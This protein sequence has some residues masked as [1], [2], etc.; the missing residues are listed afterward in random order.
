MANI[1]S[2]AYD[3][4][5]AS[6]DSR[7]ESL[8]K[9]DPGDLLKAE[10]A[11]GMI[12][13]KGLLF[14]PYVEQSSNA[15]L[16]KPKVSYL[17][18]GLL[19]QI[20]RRNTV[21]AL[22]IDLR[23]SQIA[24][25]C[26]KQ[27]SRFDLGFKIL[28]KDKS[29]KVDDEEVRR[30]EEFLLNCGYTGEERASEDKMTLDQWGY[31]VTRDL[32]VYGHCAIEKVRRRDGDLYSFLPLPAETIY[33]ANRKIDPKT[34]EGMKNIWKRILDENKVTIDD[35]TSDDVE[36]IQVI[37]GKC[38]EAFDRNELI[39]SRI[40][41][42]SDI[43]LNGYAVGP[44][45]RAIS[46][47]TSHLQIENHQR[48][49]FTHGFASKGLLVIQGD[50]TTTTLKALQQMWN[51]QITGPVNSWRTPI[52]AGIQG[53]QWTPLSPNSRDMEYAA[54][55]DYVLRLIFSAFAIDPEEVGF[56]Y[57]SRGT[58]Q[59]SLSE[60]SNEWKLT[61]SRDRGLRPILGRIEAIINEEILPAFSKK[62]SEK[63]HFAFVGVDSETQSEELA[64]LQTETALLT[65][66]DE[67]RQV[68][69]RDPLLYGGGLI[70]N[71]LYIQTAQMNMPKG[72]FMEKFMGIQGASERPDLQYIPDPMWFQWQQMQ[73][74]M[75]QQQ[76]MAEAGVSVN[77]DGDAGGGPSESDIK[78]MHSDGMTYE[79]IA[80]ET[81][82]EVAEVKRRINRSG[83]GKK[84]NEKEDQKVD[85]SQ[86]A[87]SAQ[88]EQQALAQQ[89]HV[90]AINNYINSNPELF[91]S[92]QKARQSYED[93]KKSQ[94]AD[95]KI[96]TDHVERATQ[97]L[98]KEF[99][100]ASSLLMKEIMLATKEDLDSKKD[101]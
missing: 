39:F 6:I 31:M 3:L 14:D 44:L 66:L 91:K 75:A 43:D 88:A 27:T 22:C 19:K 76:A 47:I 70:L 45:E 34:I 15:G 28:P 74:Q 85:D 46:A 93:L 42:E 94:K 56:G 98:L 30:I 101:E 21:V 65:T 72:L 18:N 63:Y 96:R 100:K 89:A 57:L 67:A 58:E 51:N 84:D 50:V 24:S 49:F 5:N 68:T 37:E 61:A 20:S 2:K 82:L 60:S 78:Q 33:Y 35:V 32:M 71:Q 13:R 99:R 90:N 53:V 10:R 17:S 38:V 86:E 54:W 8:K 92:W 9:V 62:F 1:F 36:F 87:E 79:E 4:L 23:S 52:L 77:E 25:A 97:D 48:Q 11:D 26:K 80:E 12:S 40:N 7:I 69:E 16:F 29:T 64:R 81:G 41:I 95:R 83:T 55:Q 73:I 59:R